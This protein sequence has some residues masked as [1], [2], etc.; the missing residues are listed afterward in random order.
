MNEDVMKEDYWPL[1]L[2]S[3]RFYSD[4]DLELGFSG[5]LHSALIFT[6]SNHLSC[7]MDKAASHTMQ[8]ILQS[9]YSKLEDRTLSWQQHHLTQLALL[10]REVVPTV[11]L[12]EQEN[13]K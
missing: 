10:S 6:F 13:P 7:G 3:I 9:L 12:L 8:T 11:L 4:S 2:F 1:G 5:H